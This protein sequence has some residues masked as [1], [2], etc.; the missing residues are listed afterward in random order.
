MKNKTK[1]EEFRNPVLLVDWQEKRYNQNRK[2]RPFLWIY[3][4]LKKKTTSW[5]LIEVRSCCELIYVP[6]RRESDRADQYLKKK[7]TRSRSIK[8]KKR[9]R[10]QKKKNPNHHERQK[11]RENK[12]PKAMN[13][14]ILNVAALTLQAG[15]HSVADRWAPASGFF[16]FFFVYSSDTHTCIYVYIL[17]YCLEY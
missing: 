14:H 13:L 8:N 5:L 17:A 1:D 12:T 15:S 4:L 16:F 3:I 6:G 2:Y 9:E 11:K 7:K 10:K